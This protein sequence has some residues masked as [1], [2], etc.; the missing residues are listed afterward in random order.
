M[1]SCFLD[2]IKGGSILDELPSGTPA[3]DQLIAR[4]GQQLYDTLTGPQR[5]VYDSDARFKVLVSGRRFGKTYLCIARL[6]AWAVAAPDQLCWYVTANYRMAKQIAW[7][8]LKLM[9]PTR[10]ALNE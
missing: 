4:I 9:V 7:R 8:Q 2:E 6:I 1:T 3:A 10:Y 5:A